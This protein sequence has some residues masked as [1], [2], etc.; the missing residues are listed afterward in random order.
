MK[1]LFIVPG[2]GLSEQ[3]LTRR[4][5]VLQQHSFSGTEIHIKSCRNGVRSIESYY[6]DALAT[7]A[8]IEE[9]IQAEAEGYD[10]VIIGCAGD[11]GLYAI[12]EMVRIPV[13][14]PGENAVHLASTLGRAF[15]II[16]IVDNCVPRHH[17]LVQRAGIAHTQLASIRAANMS[18]LDIAKGPDIAKRRVTEEARHALTSDGA[19]CIILG[20]LSLAF[21]LFDRELA[22]ALGV[23]VINSALAALKQ[24]ESLVSL[25]VS[26]SKVAYRLP[27]K[28]RNSPSAV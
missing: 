19:D 10:G 5:M 23:P 17:Q 1:L 15:S 25:G 18:V 27:P 16:A 13:V 8:V 7:P 12:R 9:A 2:E 26:H 3:E 24:L 14:G 6:E 4:R 20:C 21:A 22:Q 11:P 28:F